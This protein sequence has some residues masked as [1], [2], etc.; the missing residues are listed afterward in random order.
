MVFE[1]FFRLDAGGY[2][3]PEGTRQ[4]LER[5]K[6]SENSH[7]IYR[8]VYF[9]QEDLREAK[10]ACYYLRCQ[11]LG[12]DLNCSKDKIHAELFSRLGWG[13]FERPG[14]AQD[15]M[16]FSLTQVGDEGCSELM[17]EQE[18]WADELNDGRPQDA[19]L[20]LPEWVL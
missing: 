2:H 10:R 3:M 16:R 6:G 20:I 18:V 13:E 19:W 7:G 9:K 1:Y 17:R 8:A 11:T 14:D 4:A 15:F 12:R 5:F